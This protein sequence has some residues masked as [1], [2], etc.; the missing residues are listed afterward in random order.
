MKPIRNIR[1]PGRGQGRN[2]PAGYLV[3]R[4]SRGRGPM[5]L[6]DGASL[7]Q[8]GI[9]SKQSQNAQAAQC[10][11]RFFVG[12]RPGAGERIGAGVW[13]HSV[14]FENGQSPTSVIASLT[15]ATSSAVWQIETLIAGVWTVIGTITFNA[16]SLVGVLNW[17]APVTIP[18]GQ[19]VALYAPASQDATL[20]DITGTVY[21]STG[22]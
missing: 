10:G 1:L 22:V 11:F 21:G 19:Q 8:V 12:G 20:A 6:I 14:T 3:G 15:P 5:E 16:A 7:G 17:T 9:A 13:G 2:I 4:A 18:A